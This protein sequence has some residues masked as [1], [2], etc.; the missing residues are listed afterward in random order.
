MP[1]FKY[2]AV[3]KQ[4]KK[5]DG[6]FSANS[7][8]EV[9]AMIRENSYYPVAIQEVE[10]TKEIDL[11]AI[12]SKIKAKDLAVF[13]RQF[14]TLLNAGA[15]ILNSIQILKQQTQNKRMKASLEDIY[16]EIQKGSTLSSAFKKYQDV[17]PELL[18]NMIQSGEDTGN[19]STV[20]ERMSEHYEKENNINRKIRG[21]M[22]YPII[23]SVV[24]VGVIIF[25]LTFVMPQFVSMFQGSGVELPP[26]TKTMLNISN[27]IKNY[28][29]II[30]LFVVLS[31][32]ILKVLAKTVSGERIIETVKL[33]F[34]LIKNTNKKI[35]TS[36]FARSLST[37]LISGVSIINAVEVVS[38]VVGNKLVEKKL[39]TAR[40]KITKGMPLAEAIKDIESFPPM[41]VA[42]VKIGEESGALDDILEKTADFY[43]GE[44]EEALQKLTTMIEP[45]MILIMGAIVGFI[46]ISMMLPMFDMFKT[47][48]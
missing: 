3:N 11:A 5:V 39:L 45:L 2:K 29:Y 18:I 46:V 16:E 12:F 23:L 10:E 26:I 36:R 35:I 27:Y 21:A 41:L 33:N 32:T 4:G 31:I 47:V 30:I 43:D 14:Y 48:G 19:L 37:T 28:W 7:K 22:V 15:D 25:L 9:L 34:P 8:N 20:I 42:M 38:R 13:C 44:V 24:S 17:Y 40:E 6:R 1:L